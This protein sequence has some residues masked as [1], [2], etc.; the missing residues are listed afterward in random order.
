MSQNR[1]MPAGL[2]QNADT[3]DIPPAPRATQTLQTSPVESVLR[4]GDG[5]NMPAMSAHLLLARLRHKFPFLP[6]VP[7]PNTVETLILAANGEAQM[8]L[9]ANTVAIMLFATGPVYMSAQGRSAV[10][11]ASDTKSVLITQPFPFMLYVF[12][13]RNLSFIAENACTVQAWCFIDVPAGPKD[14]GFK[15]LGHL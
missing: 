2:P 6:I 11:V 5:V 7:I 15:D 14:M 12:G 13:T 1:L 10:P 3:T 8:Q 4:P 9:Q